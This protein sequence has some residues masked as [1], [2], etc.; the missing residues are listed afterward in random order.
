MSP[1]ESAFWWLGI[2][3]P[4][5]QG[6]LTF[7][8]FEERFAVIQFWLNPGLKNES[9][10][11]SSHIGWE[12]ESQPGHVWVVWA[13]F[14]ASCSINCWGFNSTCRSG[15]WTAEGK[16]QRTPPCCCHP[17]CC[18]C[19]SRAAN[20]LSYILFNSSFCTSFRGRQSR[21]ES[22]S[23]PWKAAAM[24]LTAKGSEL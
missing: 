15:S 8:P 4:C 18:S 7:Q 3:M 14:V 2:C 13:H 9:L 16:S 21:E 17:S 6:A 5:F 24:N 11:P 12:K 10:L 22:L 20:S 1:M 23:L 19:F